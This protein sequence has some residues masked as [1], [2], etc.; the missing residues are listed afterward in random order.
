MLGHSARSR[1]GFVLVGTPDGTVFLLG[2]RTTKACERDMHVL[3]CY[4]TDT[5]G[6]TQM[7]SAPLGDRSVS[8]AHLVNKDKHLICFGGA[9]GV[10]LHNVLHKD[11][12]ASPNLTTTVFDIEKEEWSLTKENSW[13]QDQLAGLTLRQGP[14]KKKH[15]DTNQHMVSTVQGNTVYAIEGNKVFRL[16]ID[17]LDAGILGLWDQCF[18]IDPTYTLNGCVD[19]GRRMAVVVDTYRGGSPSHRWTVIWNGRGSAHTHTPNRMCLGIGHLP[20]TRSRTTSCTLFVGASAP[21]LETPLLPCYVILLTVSVIS[22]L[23]QRVR[24]TSNTQTITNRRTLR[25]RR[26]S[27]RVSYI[28]A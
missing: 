28:G 15:Y 8:D 21:A 12:D 9:T 4:D 26:N 1:D 11:S 23:S 24:H 7:P 16:C 3:W 2:G 18:T 5:G 25:V 19:W 17:Q 27:V 6:W 22:T 13:P 10:H 14:R 20:A